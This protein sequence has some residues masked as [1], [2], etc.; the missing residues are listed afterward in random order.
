MVA[1]EAHTNKHPK[2]HTHP[3]T[4]VHTYLQP[5]TYT[6]SHTQEVA[7][8]ADTVPPLEIE[9]GVMVLDDASFV[10]G[11]ASA[12]YTLIKFYAPFV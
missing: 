3:P 10:D 11:V 8:E 7:D 2:A 12:E 6:Y 5:H 9:N 1:D 4:T